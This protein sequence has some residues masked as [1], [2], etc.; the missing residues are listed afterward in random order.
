MKKNYRSFGVMLV[1][2]VISILQ[3]CQKDDQLTTQQDAVTLKSAGYLNNPVNTFYSPAQPVGNGVARAYVK[4]NYDGKPVAVGISLSEKALTNLPAEPAEYVLILP[5]NKGENFYILVGLDWNPQGHEPVI[6][7]GKPHFDF[8]F[9]IITDEERMAIPFLA[10]PQMDIAPDPKYVPA[11]YIQTPGLVPEMGAHWVDVTSSEFQPGGTFTKTFIWGS[12]NGEFI[13]WEPMITL[14]YLL[15]K[16]NDL[17]T[18]RQ[19]S[20]YQ[21]DGYY[22]T[23]YKVAYSDSPGM[24]TVELQNLVFRE[25]E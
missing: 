22:A 7:Y 24:Y 12:Y 18:L 11:G 14:N 1:V 23:Q 13:F 8:H 16:P 15:T 2:G 5:K 25:G 10:P 17:V 9:Y 3:A 6:Y 19:P 20:A 4:E 21:Q